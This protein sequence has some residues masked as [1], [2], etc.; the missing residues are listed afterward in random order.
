MKNQLSDLKV[1][2]LAF[3]IFNCLFSSQLILESGRY[4]VYAFSHVAG[5]AAVERDDCE[6]GDAGQP[7]RG[8]LLFS[9]HHDRMRIER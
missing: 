3:A 9:H 8:P 6:H 5:S 2:C 4:L 1:V 7:V